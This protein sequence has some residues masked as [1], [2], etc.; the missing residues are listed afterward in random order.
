MADFSD[1]IIFADESGSPVLDGVD[2]DYPLFVLVFLVVEKTHYADV[3]V[4]SS[5][6]LKFDFV[7]HDQLI[8]HER[9]IR[10]QSADFAFL[11][12]DATQREA[13]LERINAL[14]E[15]ADMTLIC[16]VIDKQKLKKQYSDPWS[17]YDLALLFCIERA[18]NFLTCEG[19]G[20]S[21]VHVLFE[22]R[23]KKEDRHL[24]LQFRRIVDGKI[25]L[26]RRN[27]FVESG[28]LQ[29]Q[30]LFVDK[31]SNS[32]GLQLA[33][34]VAR[35]AGLNVLRPDQRN[36]AYESFAGKILPPGIK[37]FP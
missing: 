12:A 36:R 1:Y 10:R 13:F 32:A 30:P 16:A 22:S 5:Q 19:E 25:Q 18:R 17:P 8:L 2:P 6:R 20:S 27:P 3:I 34:L 7:G 31:R 26:G 23:G 15:A 28:C 29:W 14:V 24:E 9:D 35:P 21:I 4:P 37:R 33:D 11:Q